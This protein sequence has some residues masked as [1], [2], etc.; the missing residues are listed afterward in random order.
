L[1]ARN[2]LKT[3]VFDF[4]SIKRTTKKKRWWGG[5]TETV[6]FLT[7][8]ELKSLLVYKGLVYA[9]QNIKDFVRY[10]EGEPFIVIEVFEWIEVEE[11]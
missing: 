9:D 4:D 1:K 2:V 6:E 7:P 5:Y 8:L 3:L 11:V 10:E